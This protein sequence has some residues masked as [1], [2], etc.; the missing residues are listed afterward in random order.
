MELMVAG[1]LATI[2]Y[3]SFTQMFQKDHENVVKLEA[4]W[5]AQL[6]A[7][8]VTN[9]VAS[10]TATALYTQLNSADNKIGD[11]IIHYSESSPASIN[12]Q[13]WLLS[14]ENSGPR[15]KKVFFKID[16]YDRDETKSPMCESSIDNLK[17]CHKEIE[18]T[19]LYDYKKNT[20]I[21]E[22]KWRKWVV[23]EEFPDL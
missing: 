23:G 12:D 13:D 21:H 4:K 17:R 2:S 8:S 14:W 18:T 9:L 1:L 3:Y 20:K 7:E 16:I 22:V 6:V 11:G 15:I 10:M 5:R 19:V